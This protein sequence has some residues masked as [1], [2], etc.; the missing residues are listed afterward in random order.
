MTINRPEMLKWLWMLP[1]LVFLLI[2]SYRRGREQLRVYAGENKVLMNIYFI[3]S[4][5]QVLFLLCAYIAAILSLANIYWGKSFKEE[6]RNSISLAFVVDISNSML[7]AD[8][9]PSRLRKSVE[10]IKT[11]V[12]A[13]P[14]LW[15]SV[16]LFKGEAMLLVPMTQDKEILEMVSSYIHPRMMTAKGTNITAGLLMG[17]RSFP[18]QNDTHRVMIMFSDGEQWE[19]DINNAM[20]KML[21]NSVQA[22][23]VGAGTEK[24]S[25]IL[26]SNN[27]LVRNAKG[28]VVR[29]YLRKDVLNKIASFTGS[30]LLFLSDPLTASILQQRLSESNSME[31]KKYTRQIPVARYGAFLFLCVFFLTMYSVLGVVKWKGVL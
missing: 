26:L 19:G 14:D 31:K 27:D 28:N 16:T 18:S 24:G 17:I 9:K 3:K 2:W 11:I 1:P 7:A 22:Y 30:E 10:V 12:Y 15:Y 5:F 20:Q 25:T 6:Q 29:S 4:F 21:E 8:I 23:V 13:I